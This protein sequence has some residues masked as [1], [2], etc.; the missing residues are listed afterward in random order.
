MCVIRTVTPSA[1]V[2]IRSKS[3]SFFHNDGPTV[4][5]I[6]YSMTSHRS[7]RKRGLSTGAPE[8]LWWLIGSRK[9]SSHYSSLLS[10]SA[11]PGASATLSFIR[12]QHTEF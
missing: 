12:R 8:G 10:N 4:A 3:I 11:Q 7:V 5:L 1:Y 6:I 9:H 2:H